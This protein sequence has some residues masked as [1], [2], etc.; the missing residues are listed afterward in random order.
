MTWGDSLLDFWDDFS[1]DGVL[2]D[3]AAQDQTEPHLS[4]TSALELAPGET[5]DITFV[6]GWHFPNRMAWQGAAVAEASK[7]ED[8][9]ARNPETEIREMPARNANY[10]GNFYTE[11]FSDAWNVLEKFVPVLPA[12]EQNSIAFVQAFCETDLPHDVREAA[13]YNL[14]TL[15]TQTCFR[16]PDGLFFAWEGCYDKIG[17]CAGSCTHVWNY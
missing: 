12:L 6:L 14:S 5:R 10:I 3:R 8:S 13:L 16:T 15:R 7:E 9:T 17:S 4:L 1:A 11:Q 2:E